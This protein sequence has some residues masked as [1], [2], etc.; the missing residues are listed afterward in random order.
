[1]LVY[2]K[3]VAKLVLEKK[4]NINK[5]YLW[6]NFN[7][8]N[9]ISLII[10]GNYSVEKLTK[11]ELNQLEINNHQGIIIDINNYKFFSLEKVLNDK[12]SKFI[13]VLD[14]LED[15][16]NFGAILRTCECAGVDYVIIQ[17]KRSVSVTPTVMKT[18]SGALL[19]S[20]VCE[21]SSLN[22]TLDKLKENNYI[23][24]GSDMDGEDFKETK[25]PQKIALI[26]GS[27]GNG[28]KYIVKQKCDKIVSIPMKG[29][30]NSLNA[31]VAAGIL[32]Y[33]IVNRK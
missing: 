9:I 17:N 5:I 27:E 15:P 2:G 14:H 6:D 31:S 28:L 3:N 25:Y 11:N 26:I 7:D 16:H 23:I 24:I 8:K 21:V 1:M 32:I 30:V 18:S 12:E 29:K 22:S 10:K 33:E 13:V 20:K 19:Y 4:E